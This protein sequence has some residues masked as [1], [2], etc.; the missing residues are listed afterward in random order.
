M[1]LFHALDPRAGREDDNKEKE[2]EDDD[3]GKERE[4]DDKGKER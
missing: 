4:D 1:C 3:K 2:R